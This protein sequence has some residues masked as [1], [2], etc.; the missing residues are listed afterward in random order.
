MDKITGSKENIEKL[1]NL[2][3]DCEKAREYLVWTDKNKHLLGV[4]K[5][6]DALQL[7]GEASA[8]LYTF[9]KTFEIVPIENKQ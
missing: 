2:M 4:Q 6:L 5:V 7:W 1:Q 8:E 9:L 3:K